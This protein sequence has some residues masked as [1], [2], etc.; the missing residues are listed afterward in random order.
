MLVDGKTGYKSHS[1]VMFVNPQ[2]SYDCQDD[3]RHPQGLPYQPRS[4]PG[5]P[6]EE[7]WTDSAG[8]SAVFGIG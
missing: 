2:H 1:Y 7:V 5:C 8:S 6:S 4:D 3:D